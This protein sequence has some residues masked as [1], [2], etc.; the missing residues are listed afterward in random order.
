MKLASQYQDMGVSRDIV[1]QVSLLAPRA[2]FELGDPT[3]LVKQETGDASERQAPADD[4][5]LN[6]EFGDCV[7][8]DERRAREERALIEQL[9]L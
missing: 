8:D 1:S 5:D 3:A 9:Q 2:A 7:D 4:A 6:S